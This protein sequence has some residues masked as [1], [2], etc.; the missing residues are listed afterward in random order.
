M[1]AIDVH[2]PDALLILSTNIVRYQSGYSLPLAVSLLI[3]S[4]LLGKELLNDS[5]CLWPVAVHSELL[6]EWWLEILCVSTE[7]LC[8]HQFPVEPFS[9]LAARS[10]GLQ[11]Q[12]DL[13]RRLLRA[14]D[15]LQVCAR[16]ARMGSPARN[17]IKF[18]TE[19]LNSS[20]SSTASSTEA[21]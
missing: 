1:S 9:C 4:W 20:S 19:L 14:R 18:R 10:I 8:G 21:F 3:I 5:P 11:Q 7:R 17:Q 13:I 6:T 2:S 12:H 15:D 16:T